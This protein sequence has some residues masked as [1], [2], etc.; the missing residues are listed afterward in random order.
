MVSVASSLE[1]KQNQGVNRTFNAKTGQE[2]KT[3]YQSGYY[4]LTASHT[5][6][7]EAEDPESGKDPLVEYTF[8]YV[9][10]D[11]VPYTVNYLDSNRN[12][13]A[14]QKSDTTHLAV[15]T[16]NFKII[17]QYAADAFQKSLILSANPAENVITFHYTSGTASTFTVSH[18]FQTLGDTYEEE[19]DG[20]TYTFYMSRSDTVPKGGDPISFVNRATTGYEYVHYTIEYLNA[21]GTVRYVNADGTPKI[22]GE[23]PAID[24]RKILSEQ[25]E[26]TIYD[27]AEN[28]NAY[29]VTLDGTS[30]TIQRDGI[31]FRPNEKTFYYNNDGVRWKIQDMKSDG[32]GKVN[33]TIA[34]T[35][36]EVPAGEYGTQIKVYY[37]LKKYP[38]TVNHWF[39]DADGNDSLITT[40][41]KD[42]VFQSQVTGTSLTRQQLIE[43][44]YAGYRVDKDE[45]QIRITRNIQDDS[46]NPTINVINFYYYETDMQYSYQPMVVT[47][48]GD[49]GIVQQVAALENDP[50]AHVTVERETVKAVTGLASSSS[51]EWNADA[52]D[53][54]GW[55]FDENCTIPVQGDSAN[56][57]SADRVTITP[58]KI[59]EV[60][61][62]DEDG[63]DRIQQASQ[64]IYVGDYDE[65]TG[66]Y[67]EEKTFY[68]LFAPKLGSL[69]IQ[70]KNMGPEC[71]HNEASS[72]I[73]HVVQTADSNGNDL[74]DPVSMYV[75]IDPGQDR[76][77]I[78]NLPF[79]TYQ[80]VQ[81][82]SW[83][84]RYSDPKAS[85]T[86][87]KTTPY[88]VV[89]FDKEIENKAWLSGYGAVQN[90]YHE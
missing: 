22:N 29:Q 38:Y 8:Y 61:Y 85:V 56:A 63:L 6:L 69:T 15:I 84:W 59:T 9:K 43:Q 55:F 82:N 62:K 52:Y 71:G 17:P 31:T 5:L 81:E 14:D 75:T 89:E 3:D 72:F 68:A 80:V 21:D 48:P 78:S 57:V 27:A 7:M 51:A 1:G 16:E 90:L 13:I 86:I 50:N 2:L 54:V 60:H 66:R 79:G 28:G 70:R 64:G 23:T 41:T 39:K 19:F 20:K 74:K 4:P 45:K 33:I 37:D 12:P 73:Y 11:R 35:A 10:M 40:E 32:N 44:G 76:V 49:G 42:A 67:A 87:D 46:Q 83:S 24:N 53:F 30:F 25:K 58:Q 18:Y 26:F 36:V 88:P 65:A 47:T 34:P 77:T